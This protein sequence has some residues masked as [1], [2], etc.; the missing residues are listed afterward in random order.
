V[1]FGSVLGTL[2]H[3]FGPRIYLAKRFR[4]CFGRLLV[5][6]MVRTFL[7]KP[8]ALNVLLFKEPYSSTREGVLN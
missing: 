2:N 1:V 5:S 3:N 8:T 6:N 4:G 7:E